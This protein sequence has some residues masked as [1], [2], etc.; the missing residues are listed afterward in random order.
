MGWIKSISERGPILQYNVP[1]PLQLLLTQIIQ[2]MLLLKNY[3]NK[4]KH[5]FKIVLLFMYPTKID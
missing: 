3:G 4:L 1:R 2:L 5:H